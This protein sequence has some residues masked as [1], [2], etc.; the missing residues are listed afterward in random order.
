MNN[1]NKGADNNYRA[2]II[3]VS[4]AVIFCAG[5]LALLIF[6]NPPG[7]NDQQTLTLNKRIS[8]IEAHLSK[9]HP[10]RA[11]IFYKAATTEG[12]MNDL[13]RWYGAKIHYQLD[14]KALAAQ[15]LAE[16]E[17]SNCRQL[18]KKLNLNN[19]STN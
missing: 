6:S 8:L 16:C 12:Q 2:P 15:L 17:V 11:L 10:E 13:L 14:D 4:I 19:S 3:L 18:E 5:F 9:G 7:E 1:S